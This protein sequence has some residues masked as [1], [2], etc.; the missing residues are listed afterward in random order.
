MGLFTKIFGKSQPDLGPADLSVLKCDVHSHFIPGIDDGAQTLEQSIELIS[1]MHELGY[2][3]VITTPH[4]MADGYRNTPEN[5]L[6]GLETVRR[7][8]LVKGIPV[9]IEAAAEY[10]L[11]HELDRLVKEQHV[12]T[13]GDEFLLFELPFLSEPMMLLSVVFE[14]QSAG[15]RPVL[16]HPERYQYWHTDLSTMEKLKDRGVL[17]Q[18]NTIALMG[19]YGPGVKKA[20]EKIID[21]GWYEML[22]SDCHRMDHVGA[23]KA[24]LSEPYLHKIIG[25]GK[26]LNATL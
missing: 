10:Y 22:G 8:L 23:L 26:L 21:N 24:T 20:A 19:A 1:A 6:G 5:I 3:K 17:F 12:L 18:L 13:F 4:V 14:M 11:D 2:T 7:E 15:Y 25:S 16:A 9:E